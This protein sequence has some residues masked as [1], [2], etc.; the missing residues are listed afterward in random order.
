MVIITSTIKAHV[1][2]IEIWDDFLIQQI[3]NYSDDEFIFR[4]MM[5]LVILE[6]RLNFFFNRDVIDKCVY[7]W[8]KTPM[9]NLLDFT[10]LNWVKT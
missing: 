4:P 10:S 8:I 7:D 6:K 5:H 2:I 1:Y 3:E 9:D